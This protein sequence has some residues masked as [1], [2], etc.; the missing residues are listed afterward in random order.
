MKTQ[1]RKSIFETNSSSTHA[2]AISR[3]ISIKS[4]PSS[5]H[6]GL[7]D[8]SDYS[9][10]AKGMEDRA[11]FLYSQIIY[12]YDID[13]IEKYKQLIIEYLNSVGVYEIE[14]ERYYTT[15][16]EDGTTESNPWEM[17]IYIDHDSVSIDFVKEILSDK[18]TFLEYL[19]GD[20]SCIILGRDWSNI[21][22]IKKEKESGSRIISAYEYDY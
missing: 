9:V 19:F 11:D 17:D 4:Y 15:K 20:N 21:K 8:E 3:K 12:L 16:N 13:E 1:V 7:F 10:Y 5:I 6:F 2:V 18:E 22:W 14:F